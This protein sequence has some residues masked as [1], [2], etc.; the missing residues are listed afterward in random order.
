MAAF[1]VLV[2]GGD[3]SRVVRFRVP[4]WLAYGALACTVLS[5]EYVLLQGYQ[6]AEERARV[7][8]HLQVITDQQQVIEVLQRRVATIRNEIGTWEPLHAK[9]WEALGGEPQSS[10]A[11][12]GAGVAPSPTRA[13][14]ETGPVRDVDLLASSIADEGRRLRALERA[15]DHTSELMRTLP[16]RWPIHG[17]VKSEFGMR[18]S[19]WTGRADRHDGLDIGAAPGT[20]V[21]SPARGT[22]VAANQSGDYGRYVMLDHGNGIRSLYGHLQKIDTKVGEQVEIGQVIGRTGSSGR[23]T[24]PHLHYELRVDGKAVDPRRF[25]HEP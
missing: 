9:M 21:E 3:T 23:S 4:R 16:L 14:A 10:D 1:S 13:T 12:S 20:P 8:D 17:P 24:G 25:L 18:P 22:V 6:L 2:L 19:P 15:V 11:T 7:A 5:S